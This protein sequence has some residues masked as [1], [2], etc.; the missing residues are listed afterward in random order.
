MLYTDLF[1]L[2]E[3]TALITGSGSGIGFALAVALSGAGANIILNGRDEKK[4]EKA[5]EKLIRTG[6]KIFLLPFDVTNSNQVKSAITRF[7]DEIGTID[8]LINN[9]GIN[10]RE[11]FENFSEEKWKALL[12]INLN[13]AMIVSQ[14]V[15]PFMI[16]RMEGKIINICSIQ[17][18]LGRQT[19]VPYTVSKGGIKML[20]RALCAEWARYNIQVNGIGPGYFYTELTKPLSE[21]PEF[22]NWL[23]SRTPSGRWGY[24]EELAGAAIFLASKASD[25]VNG[26][27]IYVDGG[28]LSVV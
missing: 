24:P 15:G 2:E 21:N 8:I 5:R 19:I 25:Y 20:T 10:V 16:A 26:Q 13:G 27:I 6:K 12:D 9:A 3:K 23:K 22:D 11:S 1:S 14:A 28:L 7:E 18:E 4:I 17:S